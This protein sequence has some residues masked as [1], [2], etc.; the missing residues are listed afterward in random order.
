MKYG[1]TV[2]QPPR[3][4]SRCAT[5][6][7]DMSYENSRSSNHSWS[8]YIAAARKPRLPNSRAY[9]LICAARSQELLAVLEQPAVVIQIV[10]VHLEAAAPDA[11]D[12]APEA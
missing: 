6:G 4:G 9:S 10:D 3:C 1:I 12:R 5:F 7:T 8:R 2:Q 11:F